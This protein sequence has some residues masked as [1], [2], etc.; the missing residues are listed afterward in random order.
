MHE[1]G[2]VSRALSEALIDHGPVSAI[3]LEVVDPVGFSVDSTLLHLEAALA[4][5][6]LAGIPVNVRVRPVQCVECGLSAVPA[7]SELFCGACG[8]PLPRVNG[9]PLRIRTS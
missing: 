8:W 1:A 5:R 9:A 4:E 6:G 3:E 7:S 2:L